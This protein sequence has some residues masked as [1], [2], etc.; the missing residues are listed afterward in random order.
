MSL[1][2]KS[3]RLSVVGLAAAAGATLVPA[4]ASAQGYY[5]SSYNAY[6]SGSAY[7]YQDPCRDVRQGRQAAG[8][9][10]GGVLGGLLGAGVAAD[11]AQ[12]EGAALG[13]V[14][15]AVA[16]ASAGGRSVD[17]GVPLP[18]SGV[19]TVGYGST[20]YGSGAYG[21]SGSGYS[22]AGQYGQGHYGS[23]GYSPA[24]V[25]SGHGGYDPRYQDG[26]GDRAATQCE[27]VYRITRLPDGRE[28]REPVEACREAY[29]GDWDVERRRYRH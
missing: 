13:A 26:Y 25:Y 28:I 21:H 29:Y 12:D 1:R 24:P 6:G 5:G 2:Q 7:G 8:A 10:I 3:V 20:S 9:V 16:G 18:H 14:L 4:A 19:S 15:G 17:C 23:R 11:N 27:T 22:G